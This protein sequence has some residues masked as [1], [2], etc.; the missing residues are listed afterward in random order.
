MHLTANGIAELVASV[1]VSS[2]ILI[3]VLAAAL[4][5]AVRPLLADWAELRS[6]PNDALVRRLTELEEEV[7]LLRMGAN[8]QLPTES[9]QPGRQRT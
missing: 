1:F 9:L 8:L 2:S 3:G 4:R 7:R 6:T 5:F